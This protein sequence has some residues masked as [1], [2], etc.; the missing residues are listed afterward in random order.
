MQQVPCGR[1]AF[2]CDDECETVRDVVRRECP[3]SDEKECAVCYGYLQFEATARQWRKNVERVKERNEIKVGVREERIIEENEKRILKKKP[4]FTCP[5]VMEEYVR[6]VVWGEAT[7][8]T[9]AVR[10]IEVRH[11]SSVSRR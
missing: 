6:R 4:K 9:D 10:R 7:E 1:C 8:E 2:R 5:Q 3:E 11:P